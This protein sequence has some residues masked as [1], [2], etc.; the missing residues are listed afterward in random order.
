MKPQGCPLA[1][2]SDPIEPRRAHVIFVDSLGFISDYFAG[3]KKHITKYL[4]GGLAAIEH[5]GKIFVFCTY[6]D[7][8]VRFDKRCMGISSYVYE[9]GVWKFGKIVLKAEEGR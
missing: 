7:R 3:E 2:A 9:D 4:G 5:Q 8:S 1:V 6:T